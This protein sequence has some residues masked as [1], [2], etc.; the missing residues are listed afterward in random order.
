MK[1]CKLR[2]AELT[3]D[4][5]ENNTQRQLLLTL[6]IISSQLFFPGHLHKY[7]VVEYSLF[8]LVCFNTRDMLNSKVAANEFSYVFV[9]F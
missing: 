3:K 9:L 6:S 1:K 4:Y 7:T 5:S 8:F 2:S